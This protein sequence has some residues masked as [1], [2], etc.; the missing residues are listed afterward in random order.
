MWCKAV[1]S[2]NNVQPENFE[3][4]WNVRGLLSN[5]YARLNIKLEH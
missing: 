3:N 2:N 5:A 1:D 4:I